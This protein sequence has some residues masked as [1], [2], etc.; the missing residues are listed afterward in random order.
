M[1]GR[2]SIRQSRREKVQMT[3]VTDSEGEGTLAKGFKYGK[4][5]TGDSG[6]NI[7][8]TITARG[9]RNHPGKKSFK[10]REG[11][12]EGG[13]EE[14]EEDEQ[15][16]VGFAEFA[17]GVR[18]CVLCEEL[19]ARSALLFREVGRK[20]RSIWGSCGQASNDL[21]PPSYSSSSS[22]SS[23]PSS[24]SPSSLPASSSRDVSTGRMT[25]QL[26]PNQ[27][28]EDGVLVDDFLLHL[29]DGR[30][31]ARL[32]GLGPGVSFDISTGVCRSRQG[33]KWDD[34]GRG[35]M[36]GYDIQRGDHKNLRNK[37]FGHGHVDRLSNNERTSH[38]HAGQSTQHSDASS[39]S[40]P[41]SDIAAAVES[42]AEGEEDGRVR[43]KAFATKLF[44]LVHRA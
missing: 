25:L 22:S 9:R 5:L 38:G 13:S 6:S 15:D 3:G 14:D 39:V 33:T 37:Q 24:S 23:S 32:L 17:A 42:A 18:S 8:K 43:F 26:E 29:A 20:D 4:N 34:S 16:I 2:R 21:L 1:G 35:E 31:A 40:L 10:Q 12:D 19:F 28:K 27:R 11:N 44:H 36:L 41:Y 7:E 30:R